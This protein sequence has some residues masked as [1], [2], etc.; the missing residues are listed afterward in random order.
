MPILVAFS[1]LNSHQFEAINMHFC[2]VLHIVNVDL[3][4]SFYQVFNDWVHDVWKGCEVEEAV[5]GL[6]KRFLL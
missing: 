1:S 6:W 3:S 4:V 2:S 5:E